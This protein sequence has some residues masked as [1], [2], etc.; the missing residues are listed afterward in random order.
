M[1]QRNKPSHLQ[2]LDY[3][4]KKLKPYKGTGRA[5]SL[6]GA[7]LNGC[8]HVEKC[9]LIHIYHSAKNFESK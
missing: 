9:K 5:S 2:T 3:L 4:T 1:D 8:L 6:I 7:G